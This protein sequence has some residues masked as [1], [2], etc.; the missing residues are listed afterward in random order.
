MLIQL[1]VLG[2]LPRALARTAGDYKALA[3][4]VMFVD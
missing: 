3:A 4:A 2:R 1:F